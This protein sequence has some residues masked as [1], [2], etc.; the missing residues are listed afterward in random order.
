[1]GLGGSC[2][3]TSKESILAKRR[4]D[5]CTIWINNTSTE[6]P[7]LVI[8]KWLM[9]TATNAEDRQQKKKKQAGRRQAT[10]SGMS[11]SGQFLL[12]FL[13]V[14]LS[15]VLVLH[16]FVPD[17]DISVKMLKSFFLF[18][19]CLLLLCMVSTFFTTCSFSPV[20]HF[21][22]VDKWWGIWCYVFLAEWHNFVELYAC[23]DI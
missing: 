10:F 11:S 3:L 14:C 1:M 18:M 17:K 15:S 23:Y 8:N 9:I 20:I 7:S 21:F 19:T 13:S 16:S 6:M 22:S 5:T 2:I 12:L 4:Q